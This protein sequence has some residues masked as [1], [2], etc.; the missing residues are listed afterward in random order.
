ML[1]ILADVVHESIDYHGL[2]GSN[3]FRR[4]VGVSP[5]K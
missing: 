5:F 3:A 1:T 2:I 4:N